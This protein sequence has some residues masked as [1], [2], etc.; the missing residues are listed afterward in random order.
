VLCSTV[1]T[2]W[3]S[4]LKPVRMNGL[5]KTPFM[6]FTEAKIFTDKHLRI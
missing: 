3:Y 6:L 4:N 5:A 2:E 1:I